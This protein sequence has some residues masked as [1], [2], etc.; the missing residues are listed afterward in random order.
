VQYGNTLSLPQSLVVAQAEPGI[1]TANEQGTGQGSITKSD[2]VTVAQPG[3]P[4]NIGE[5]IVIYCTG[6]GLVTPS[7]KEGTA[8]PSTPPLATTVNPV[9][10]TIGGQA[11]QVSFSGLAPG[12]AGLYQV[13]AV[14]P[15]GITVGNAVPVVLSVAGQT[16]PPATIAVQ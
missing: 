5:T 9:T 3:T 2:G 12:Y 13:N 6:L 4:A 14:V 15:A 16:S 11:A 8:A 10:V 1:F 7:V